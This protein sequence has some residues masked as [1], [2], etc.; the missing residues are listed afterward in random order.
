MRNLNF[1]E[2]RIVGSLQEAESGVPLRTC[3]RG[4][5]ASQ[6]LLA[7]STWRGSLRREIGAAHRR[8]ESRSA[9]PTGAAAGRRAV[10]G[11]APHSGVLGGA[12]PR[13]SGPEHE[14]GGGCLEQRQ[15]HPDRARLQPYDRLP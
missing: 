11:L 12:H 4:I 13:R 9:D 3:C 2:P 1:S 14:S 15:R 5:S 10:R 8:R 7:V 6:S